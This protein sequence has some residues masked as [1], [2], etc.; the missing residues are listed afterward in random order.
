MEFQL[1]TV[2]FAF[3]NFLVLLFLL[4]KFLYGPVCNMLDKRR[5]EVVG[6]LNQA[7]EAKTEAQKLR[8]DYAAQIKDAKNEAQDIINRAA[9]IGEQTKNDIISEARDEANKVS[10]KAQEEIQR[11][12]TQA[13]NELRGEVANLAVLAAEKI[14]GKTIEVKDHEAMINNFVKEVGDAK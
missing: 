6:N 1:G 4:K 2:V 11:E 8:D 10:Q 7:E 9:K 14:V 5:E 3:I 12:K 13:L